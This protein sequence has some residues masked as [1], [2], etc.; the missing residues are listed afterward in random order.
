MVLVDSMIVDV[1]VVAPGSNWRDGIAYFQSEGGD[2]MDNFINNDTDGL[3]TFAFIGGTAV[4]HDFDIASKEDTIT[5]FPKLIF[6]TVATGIDNKKES[7]ITEYTLNQ[8]YPN[9]FNPETTISYNLPRAEHVLL[10]IYNL[11]G[12]KITTLV[13]ELKSNGQHGISWDGKNMNGSAV[14]SGVY[15]YRIMAGDF[16]QSNKMLLVR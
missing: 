12:E 11:Q 4:D 13:N 10:R 1:D 3:L 9:P 5:H 16:V 7:T 15:I 2:A 14:A 6:K 8:N